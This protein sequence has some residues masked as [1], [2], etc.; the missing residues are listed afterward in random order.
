MPCNDIRR[1]EHGTLWRLRLEISLDMALLPSSRVAK[2]LIVVRWLDMAVGIAQLVCCAACTM[3]PFKASSYGAAPK[4][5]SYVE[6]PH[7][8]KRV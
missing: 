3:L 7:P 5:A 4:Y 8:L 1:Q 2:A 6:G